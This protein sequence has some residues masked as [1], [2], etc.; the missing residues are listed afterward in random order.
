MSRRE[1][2]RYKIRTEPTPQPLSQYKERKKDGIQGYFLSPRWAYPRKDKLI[3]AAG[4]VMGME[5][6]DSFHKNTKRN[7]SYS[8]R[9]SVGKMQ[10]KMIPKKT[11]I[12]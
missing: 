12:S 8:R 5:R 7:E 11:I 9:S 6:Y 4:K 3:H 2:G 10:W 1:D